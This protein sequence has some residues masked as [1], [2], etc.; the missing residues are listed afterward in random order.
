M[1]MWMTTLALLGVLLSLPGVARTEEDPTAVIETAVDELSQALE[2][3]KLELSE[4]RQELYEVIDG[5]LL[6]RF[7]RRYAAQLVLGRYW[8]TGS[9]E[10]QERF[11]RAFYQAL[12]ERYADG[13]LEFDEERIEVLPFR[14]DAEERRTTVRTEVKL[15]DGSKVPVNYGL[16]KRDDGW[17]VYDVTVEGIS[18]VRNFRTELNAEI[19]SKGLE[20]VIQ[21]L[22]REAGLRE[23]EG[24]DSGSADAEGTGEE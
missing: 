19:A 2:G 13:V 11:I 14:G 4:N 6:P 15:D 7:D 8:R 20:P 18:Y 5:I 9:E 1:R 17:K 12:L 24:G 3:R 10:Q 23:G 22:E 21:R 16:V